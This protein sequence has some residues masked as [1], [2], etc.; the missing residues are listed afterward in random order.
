MTAESTL[1]NRKGEVKDTHQQ[2]TEFNPENDSLNSTQDNHF[3]PTSIEKDI[4]SADSTSSIISTSSSSSS[5]STGNDTTDKKHRHHHHHHPKKKKSKPFLHIA[6]LNT[7][8]QHRLETIGIMWH[9]LSIPFFICLFLL[10]ISVGWIVWI[11]ILVPYFI[12]WYGYD[13]H[14]PTNGKVAYRVQNWM[15]NLVVWEW[16]VNYFPIRVHKTVELEPTFTYILEDVEEEAIA[17]DDEQDLISEN[18]RTVIDQVFKFL[19]LQKRLNDDDQVVNISPT[20]SVSTTT[21]TKKHVHKV[22]TGPRYIFGYHPHGVISMGVMGTFATNV[23]R[24]EPWKPPLRFLKPLFHDTTKGERLFP[25][26]GDIF[27]L[28]I[29]TQFTIPFYRDY[30]LSMGLTSASAKNIK[31]LINNGDNSVC[32]VVGGAQES[33]LNHMVGENSRVGYGFSKDLSDVEEVMEVDDYE[34]DEVEGDIGV[35][36]SEKPVDKEIKEEESEDKE[37]EVQEHAES[38]EEPVNSQV[39]ED[40]KDQEEVKV[41]A[42]EDLAEVKQEQVKEE[43]SEETQDAKAEIKIEVD[44]PI[45][46]EKDIKTDLNEPA[47]ETSQLDTPETTVPKREVRLIL[48]KR[49]GF[50][51]LAIELGNV[52]LVP[53]FAFGEADIYHLIV[54]EPGSWGYK[55]QQLVKDIFQF[56]VPFFSARGVFIYDFGLLPYRNPIN[57]CFG[58]PIYVPPN[59]LQDYIKEHPEEHP[60][61]QTESKEPLKSNKNKH[62]LGKL[63]PKYPGSSIR[64]KMPQELLDHYHKLYVEELRRVFEENK[65][66]FGYGDVELNIIE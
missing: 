32:I 21:K 60:E 10:T 25:G 47:A 18:S 29:T 19:G 3:E 20:Q 7:P 48:N 64:T 36:E 13:L 30:L 39:E 66:K 23:L 58:R 4:S 9:C 5:T 11:C 65:D 62:I 22:S 55:F 51:K 45:E 6:P 63:F 38:V 17:K 54:P 41:E 57:I 52:S 61:V 27:P 34:E 37:P 59:A 1:R 42:K 16:F 43:S 26:I 28:T 33:L 35:D 50:V 56:T 8:L 2:T 49:K 44:E 31:S 46:Q 14:T 53:T 15:K 12:W 24:N 40:R